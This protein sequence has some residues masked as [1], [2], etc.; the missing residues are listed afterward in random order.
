MI[1]LPSLR[2]SI[3]R[4]ISDPIVT[5][6]GKS[7]LKPDTLT[8]SGLAISVAAA[9]AIAANYLIIGGLLVLISGLFDILD[10][11]LARSTK[12]T[13]HFGAMLDSTFD[14]LSEAVLFLGLLVLYVMN[15]SPTAFILSPETEYTVAIVLIF[16]ALAG[17]FLTSYVRARAEGIGIDCQVGLFTRVERVIMLTLGLLFNQIIIALAIVVVLAFVTV[18]QRLVYVRRQVRVQESK[19][20][21]GR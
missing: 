6:L 14:R 3:A 19:E 1:N 13:T 17:S 20:I 10:G 18:G 5:F 8:W 15:F 12:Q 7:R 21:K 4:Q 2:K 9:G 16:L 11:A